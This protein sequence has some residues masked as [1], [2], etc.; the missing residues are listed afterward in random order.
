MLCHKLLKM[1][2]SNS[3]G[4]AN[5]CSVL[6]IWYNIKY[7]EFDLFTFFLSI[8]NVFFYQFTSFSS[9]SPCMKLALDISAKFLIVADIHRPVCY[10]LNNMYFLLSYAKYHLVFLFFVITCDTFTGV[11]TTNLSQSNVIY[12]WKSINTF[13]GSISVMLHLI[14]KR[15]SRA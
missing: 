1:W 3:V 13:L 11:I 14:L 2:V 10:S 5:V 7:K 15:S 4:R 6:E 8:L 12:W 9:S